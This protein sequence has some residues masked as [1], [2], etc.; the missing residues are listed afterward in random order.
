VKDTGGSAVA[1]DG[2]GVNVIGGPLP[3]L[4]TFGST[5]TPFFAGGSANVNAWTTVVS[6]GVRH[7]F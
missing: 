7:Q 4:T 6:V 1:T 5:E 3:V 2:A